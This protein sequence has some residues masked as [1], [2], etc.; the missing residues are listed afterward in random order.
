MT[1]EIMLNRMGRF[2]SKSKQSCL[3]YSYMGLIVPSSSL[4]LL[5]RI[6]VRVLLGT[7]TLPVT[8]ALRKS[9]CDSYRV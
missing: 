5:L 6:L 9:K 8:Y 3:V 7:Q 4:S 1:V 2:C